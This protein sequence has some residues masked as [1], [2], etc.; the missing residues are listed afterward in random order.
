MST[1]SQSRLIA[2]MDA[3]LDGKELAEQPR[4]L[5]L[6]RMCQFCLL[7]QPDKL[8]RYWQMLLAI[9]RKLPDDLKEDWESLKSS[10][11]GSEEKKGFTAEMLA[12]VKEA[13]DLAATDLEEAKRR[14]QDCET[15]LRKRFNPFGKGPVWKALVE[16]WT[17]ID[18]SY[19]LGL[20]K[21]ISAALQGSYVGKMN[22]AQMLTPQEWE[23]LVGALGK[24]RAEQVAL[25]LLEDAEQAMNLPK[26]IAAGVALQLCNAVSQ[27]GG[28][29]NESG[30][31]EKFGQY[32]RLLGM[33]SSSQIAHKA[34]ELLEELYVLIAKTAPLD[35]IWMVRFS[36]LGAVI[37]M[38]VQLQGKG[39][40]VMDEPHM[41]RL[42]GKTPSQLVPFAW[43]QWAGMTAAGQVEKAYAT[44]MEKTGQDALAEA[45][46]LVTLV[47]Q[48]LAK[49]AMVL[50]RQSPRADEL[51][52]RLRRAWLSTDP[53][54]ARTEIAVADMAGDPIG[55]FLAQGG[56]A[57]RAAYLQS[58]TENGARSVPGALWAGVGTEDEPEGLRGF[59][60]SLSTRK[61]SHDEIIHA[62][63]VANPLYSSYRRDTKKEDHF[64]EHLRVNGYG[65][66]SYQKIDG[67]LL[68][69]LVAWGDQ[70]P[71]Q[72][73]S[74][75]RGMWQAIRPDD[76]ILMVDWLRNAI[77][78]RCVNVFAADAQVLTD[79][80]LGWL[81]QE[82]VQKGRQWR[83][84]N[85][86]MTLKYPPTAPLQFALAAASTVGGASPRRRDEVL[87]SGL[88]KFEANPALIESAAQLYNSDKQPLVLEPPVQLKPNLVASWQTGIVK[89]A[90][91]SILKTMAS[92]AT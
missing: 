47:G 83:F 40:D 82:L 51:L 30:M 48:G 77:M 24:G 88:R 87:L 2:T 74:V 44:V 11:E 9:Q 76:Q 14:L 16:V 70:E 60:K 3:L 41:Q 89:N 68:S 42:I 61:K 12:E 39:V 65:E 46:F 90:L 10:L 50:A 1:E 73:R 34:Q 55:E 56:A 52:P 36:L 58:V 57:Q 8:E 6:L 81:K 33:V 23:I 29:G 35:S 78:T 22:K 38:G 13:K 59:W 91:P 86:I 75:L 26:E 69:A 15:R 53:E 63:L 5:L 28:Q 32:S 31:L 62:Y 18:R 20:L 27:L 45:W 64:R 7:F 21:Q 54:A 85:Q 4:A 72:V 79:D 71:Q 43:A 19:A 80:Y 49:D 92:S 84:G 25:K 67:A 66:Y 37:G 17:P